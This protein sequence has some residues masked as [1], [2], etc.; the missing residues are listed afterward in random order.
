MSKVYIMC[1]PPG[2]GKSTAAMQI[3]ND[4]P[5]MEYL[6][7]DCI[8]KEVTGD[9]NDMSRDAEVWGIVMS[10]YSHFLKKGFDIILDATNRNRKSRKRFGQLAELAGY[11]VIAVDCFTGLSVEEVQ[12]RNAG[13]ARVVPSDI[14]EKKSF[15][16]NSKFPPL[17]KGFRRLSPSTR[18]NMPET[19]NF[20]IELRMNW[21]GEYPHRILRTPAFFCEQLW[22]KNRFDNPAGYEIS[23]RNWAGVDEGWT[24]TFWNGSQGHDIATRLKTAEEAKKACEEHLMNMLKGIIQTNK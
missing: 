14:V 4:N 15:V 19:H 24:A 2:C 13:R 21:G 20:S 5:G 17:A 12:R 22:L 23:L 7:S 8:R 10:Q 11:E 6:S 1:G 16:R 18:N 9:D 3:L